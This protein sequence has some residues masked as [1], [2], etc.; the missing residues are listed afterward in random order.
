MPVEPTT[1]EET[2]EKFRSFTVR[3]PQSLYLRMGELARKE[4]I[5]LNQK[6]NQLLQLGL[7]EHIKLD[8]ILLRLI[9]IKL[10]DDG[11]VT[12]E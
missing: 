11:V 10:L 3:V 8:D 12:D 1:A 2:T 9:K 6:V 7:G 4:N 5:Y